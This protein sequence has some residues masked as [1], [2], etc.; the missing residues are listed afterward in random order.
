MKDLL[1]M[2]WSEDMASVFPAIEK[3]GEYFLYK[4]KP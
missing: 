2:T 3:I 1:F 4:F